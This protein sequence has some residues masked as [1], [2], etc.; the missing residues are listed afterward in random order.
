[1]RDDDIPKLSRELCNKMLADLENA[2]RPVLEAIKC[3]LD[4]SRYNPKV[5]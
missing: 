5:G 3:S 2:R 4:N 1:M